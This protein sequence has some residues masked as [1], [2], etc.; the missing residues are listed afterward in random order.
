[1][2]IESFNLRWLERCSDEMPNNNLRALE[3]NQDSA[4]SSSFYGCLAHR[5]NVAQQYVRGAIALVVIHDLQLCQCRT[6]NL[7]GAQ[8]QLEYVPMFEGHD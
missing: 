5:S 1:M 8:R 3:G 2:W 7:L 6:V 4:A